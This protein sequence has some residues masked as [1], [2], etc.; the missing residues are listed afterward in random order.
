M[1]PQDAKVAVELLGVKK[2]IPVHYNTWPLI[3]Q[4]PEKFKT[5]VEADGQTKVFVVDP[6]DSLELL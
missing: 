2:I 4:D 5:E 1:G 6:G 3:A